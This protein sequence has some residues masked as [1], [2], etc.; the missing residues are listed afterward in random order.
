MIDLRSTRILGYAL[1]SSR[2]YNSLAIRTV[3]TKVCDEHGLPR[4]GFYFEMG[5]WKSSRILTGDASK[6][7][8][9]YAEVEGGLR[10][11]GLR[12]IHAKLPRAKP[13]EGVIGAIQNLLEGEP[14]YCGRDERHDKF[15]RVQTQ[16]RLVAAKKLHP[17]GPFRSADA[18]LSRLDQ[19]FEKYNAA[20]QDG[21]MTGGL[22]PDEAFFKFQNHGDPQIKFDARCRF[23]LAHHRRPVR[24][25]ANGITIRI[26]KQS[27][28]Y[29]NEET[30]RMIGETAFAWFN[31]ETPE[32]LCVTDT[33]NR[34]PFAVQ[35]AEDVPAIDASPELMSEEMARIGA[36]QKHTKSYYHILKAKFAPKFRHNLVDSETAEL[37]VEFHRQGEAIK[38]R[39]REED[40]RSR[41]V[42]QISRR[43]N[44]TLS[45]DAR[46]RPE[47]PA[48]LERLNEL[49][50]DD[51]DKT[52]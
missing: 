15:E 13:I 18:W 4:K 35:R 29:R 32:I 10:D 5:I 6:L 45:P 38:S 19:V 36:H 31:P 44:M 17:E 11:L 30:G 43:L 7:P 2:N 28:T 50:N 47:S 49:L 41:K 8:L 3:I 33:K 23:L 26:G 21:K 42:E 51:S 20:P 46:R 22:S 14:G 52:L 12:F 39:Q 34:N 48:A 37:G 1:L 27:F 9:S 40:T 25:T 16:L 24:V